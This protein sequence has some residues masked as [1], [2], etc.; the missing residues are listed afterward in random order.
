MKPNISH[1]ELTTLL[2]YNPDTGVF[3][4]KLRWWNRQPGDTLGCKSPQNY[5][6]IGVGGKQYPAH[7]LAWF[8]VHKE[9]PP[10]D[11]DHINRNRLDNRISNL[12]AVTRSQNLHNATPRNSTKTSVT[13]VYQTPK[14]K[15]KPW[16]ASITV[17]YKRIWLGQ[18][19]TKEAAIAARKDAE[20]RLL[21][22]P[23]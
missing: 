12:R 17:N 1:D 23:P 7:R 21:T 18:F 4:Q 10:G 9:W 19:D 15:G 13:G 16:R 6:Y 11:I 8:Y 20:F 14:G 22:S 5:W 2:H 3:T